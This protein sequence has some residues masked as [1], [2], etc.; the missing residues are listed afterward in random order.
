MNDLNDDQPTQSDRAERPKVLVADDNDDI[1]DLLSARLELRGFDV[2]TAP[3]GK[4]ALDAALEHLP[5]VIVLDWVMPVIQGHELCVKL[6]TD[7]LTQGIPVMM[8]T[9]RGEEEDRLLGM[10]LGA[11]AYMVKPFDIDEL[12]QTLRRLLDDA[13]GGGPTN[14]LYQL[15]L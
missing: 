9:A 14:D 7:P 1:R 5:D 6:K 2:I 8:L 15:L 4:A 11:D 3:D 12:E 13:A 10:D